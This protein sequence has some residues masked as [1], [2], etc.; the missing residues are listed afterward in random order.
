LH[1]ERFE[2]RVVPTAGVLDSSFGTGGIVTTDFTNS[3]FI[4]VDKAQSVA[5]QGDGKII[6]VGTSDANGNPDFALARYN[7][8]GSL[9]TS[10]GTGGKVL[11]DF[12]GQ[13]DNGA[14]VA[15]QP[16]GKILV[17]G[18]TSEY[19]PLTGTTNYF[20]LARYNSDGTL[21]STFGNG[22]LAVA[23]LSGSIADQVTG[24]A[25]MGNGQIVVCGSV[26]LTGNDEF[27]AARFNANGTLDTLFGDNGFAHASFSATSSDDANAVV[28]QSNGAV[29]LAGFTLVS[30]N[31]HVGVMRFT[32]AGALDT[33]FD[34]GGKVTLTEGTTD[35][36][37]AV[38][39]QA[40]GKI[41]LGGFTDLT[42]TLDFALFRL[43]NDGSL[44]T[45]FGASGLVTTDFAPAGHLATDQATSVLV[46]PDGK[47][48][49]AGY[50]QDDQL[51]ASGANNLAIAR[52]NANGSLDTSF[53][54]GGKTVTDVAGRNDE[55]YAVTTQADGKLVVAGATD[56]GAGSS[57]FV[58]ARYNGDGVVN[59]PPTANAGGPYTV[60]EGGSVQLN[61]SGSTP[62]TGTLTYA[63]DLNGNGIFGEAGET[64]VNPTFSA[65]NL[66]GPSQVTVYLRVTNSAG[67]SDTTSAVINVT[68][69]APTVNVGPNLTVNEGSLVTLHSTVTDPGTHDTFTYAWTVR[70]VANN[71]VAT[72]NQ[73][74]LNFTPPDNGTYTATLVV[75]DHAGA[76]G[77]ASLVITVNNVAPTANA[78][79]NLSCIEGATVVFHGSATDPG[80]AD[81][82]TYG[83]VVKNSL[84]QTVAGGSGANFSF[85][86][87]QSGV[88]TATLTATD[89][90]GGVGTA[91]A[92]LSVSN[93]PPVATIT[94]VVTPNGMNNIQPNQKLTFSGMFTDVSP[95]DSHTVTWIWG[96]GTSDTTSYGPSSS[97]SF[98]A[99]HSYASSGTY[100]VTLQVTDSAGNV[101]TTQITLVVQKKNG[102]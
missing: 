28:L 72:G 26:N 4:S 97:Q 20:A 14:G 65:A 37:Q 60:A 55:A 66:D 88:Y 100:T 74:T 57:D 27:A 5:V 10:F 90:D 9:D 41:V 25:L 50:T 59:I 38:A 92:V 93:A 85:T 24:L 77:T 54:S 94:G 22:G 98:T 84:G 11:T 1:L 49:A 32:S 64:G 61:G 53:G 45:G 51:A 2:D 83:W 78:G 91:S 36:A 89:K 39:L 23:T 62:G 7:A 63:W 79:P 81:T 6:A 52:Y 47:I 13:A 80:T 46:A 33:S 73:S 29:V 76:T 68:N 35:G 21:D 30:G 96:D 56:P 99:K 31:T 44:D 42:G 69:V 75:T 101:T 40:D 17:A 3:S 8:D 15:L 70:N 67:L 71:I 87:A 58:V 18:S 43:N 82:I 48:V 95:S 102:K 12:F 86:P 19:N 16:D 34:G